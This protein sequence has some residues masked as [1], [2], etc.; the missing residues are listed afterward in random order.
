MWFWII[1]KL[2]WRRRKIRIKNDIDKIIE[3]VSLLDLSSTNKNKQPCIID[4]NK[5]IKLPYKFKNFPSGYETKNLNNLYKKA[6]SIAKDK[7]NYD[8]SKIN[9]ILGGSSLDILS[10][11]ESI[12]TP[13][14]IEK[15]YTK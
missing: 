2:L 13:Y 15:L 14:Y 3:N 7:Y 10:K 6:L 5:L 11:K 1:S 4:Y 8:I 12:D 9:F